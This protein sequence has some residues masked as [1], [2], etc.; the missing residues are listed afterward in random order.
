IG[1]PTIL[2]NEKDT[3][4]Y[5][6]GR[7]LARQFEINEMEDMYY[8]FQK[9]NWGKIELMQVK[10]HQLTFHLMADEIVERL[11]SPIETEF[12][13]ES[14]FIAKV[15]QNIHERGYECIESVNKRLY[16]IEFKV[17]F[18]D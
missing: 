3:I 12:R 14:S 4:L 18:T 13:I 16:R 9:L 8:V 15:V 2:G 17:H 6:F 11:T 5:F 1:L 7:T 10:K